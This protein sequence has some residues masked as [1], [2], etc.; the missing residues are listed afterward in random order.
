MK[1]KPDIKI[2]IPIL[3]GTVVW[4]SVDPEKYAKWLVE[5]DQV[6][7]DAH[8]YAGMCH[9]MR[10]GGYDHQVIYLSA[11]DNLTIVHECLHAAFQLLETHGIEVTPYNHE[12][13]AYLQGYL[14]EEITKRWTKIIEKEVVE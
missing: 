5:T 14:A 10:F 11:F 6:V 9:W 13:L 7:E 4:V 1:I 2:K 8:T 12:I 3:H